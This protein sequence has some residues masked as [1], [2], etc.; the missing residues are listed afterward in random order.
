MAYK[1]PTGKQVVIKLVRSP[2]GYSKRQKGTVRA[3]GLRRLL[4]TVTQ[5]DTPV[6]RGMLDRVSHLVEVEEA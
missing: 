6:L 2:I 1:K 5:E 3:L 4:Q